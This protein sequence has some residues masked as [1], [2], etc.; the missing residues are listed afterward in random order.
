M[1][2]CASLRPLVESAPAA[3]YSSISQLASSSNPLLAAHAWRLSEHLLLEMRSESC[4]SSAP[5]QAVAIARVPKLCAHGGA[6]N[7]GTTGFEPPCALI[8]PLEVGVLQGGLGKQQQ[9][10]Q[11]QQH[12]SDSS[13][14]SSSNSSRRARDPQ[15]R[16]LHSRSAAGCMC[17]RMRRS[18]AQPS[19]AVSTHAACQPAQAAQSRARSG[20]VEP[21]GSIMGRSAGVQPCSVRRGGR[22]AM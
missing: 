17:A 11:Q 9:Q 2:L 13:S 22:A 10:Q 5:D 16:A 20:T 18:E 12:A 3:S 7:E 19:P 1:P 8:W 4:R 21:A 15:L 6:R 14:S